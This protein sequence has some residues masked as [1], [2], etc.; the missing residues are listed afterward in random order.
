[1]SASNPFGFISPKNGRA[2]SSATIQDLLILLD[3][4]C[5]A[6][7][8][9]LL[10]QCGNDVLRKTKLLAPYYRAKRHGTTSRFENYLENFIRDFENDDDLLAI[11]H[12]YKG[13]L[14]A[15]HKAKTILD[16]LHANARQHP[17]DSLVH[18]ITQHFN[19]KGPFYN[20]WAKKFN[21]LMDEPTE[22]NA[23][24]KTSDTVIPEEEQALSKQQNALHQLQKTFMRCIKDKASKKWHPSLDFNLAELTLRWHNYTK[25]HGRIHKATLMA[26]A[27]QSIAEE[28]QEVVIDQHLVAQHT[29][30]ERKAKHNP[31]N[32]QKLQKKLQAQ[33]GR[34]LAKIEF[35]QPEL[36]KYARDIADSVQ[37]I[38]NPAREKLFRKAIKE[39]ERKELSFSSNP[40]L[41]NYC[42]GKHRDPH[43]L[44]MLKKGNELR[45]MKKICKLLRRELDIITSKENANWQLND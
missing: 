12:L 11:N 4:F 2:T 42:T 5:E 41:F 37:D 7:H 33:R 40:A 24:N 45:E 31:A 35:S 36:H 28:E 14:A 17:I 39:F 23:P 8:K 21:A 1:M 25:Q 43:A 44:S 15:Y 16:E 6:N 29:L 18:S 9:H 3:D 20:D 38:S 22:I 32:L 27:T 30:E 34:L 13:L 19:Y 10:T 26:N